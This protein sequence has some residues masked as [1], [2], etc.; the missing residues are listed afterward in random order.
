MGNF[1]QFIARLAELTI[2]YLPKLV[3]IDSIHY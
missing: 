1:T 2:Y 3:F